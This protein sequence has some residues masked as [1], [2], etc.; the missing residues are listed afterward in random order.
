MHL[1]AG[2]MFTED[3]KKSPKHLSCGGF[4]DAMGAL[5]M[6]FGIWYGLA[7]WFVLMKALD[8]PPFLHLSWWW[9]LVP[10]LYPSLLDICEL[11]VK[12]GERFIFLLTDQRGR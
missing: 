5:I 4:S 10:V 9:V 2:V 8:F 1:T 6:M 7:A 12:F 11:L 3:K